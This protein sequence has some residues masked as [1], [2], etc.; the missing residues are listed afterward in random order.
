MPVSFEI[1]EVL[2]YDLFKYTFCP[3]FLLF[4]LWDSNQFNIV[5]LY[6]IADLLQSSWG[7]RRVT[8]FLP[9]AGPPHREGS[10]DGAM[11]HIYG[12]LS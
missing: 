7:K 12:K 9:V 3:S 8:T 11:V 2:S 4:F 1:R 6:G 10:P 5:L